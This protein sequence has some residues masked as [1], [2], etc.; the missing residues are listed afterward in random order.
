MQAAQVAGQEGSNAAGMYGTMGSYK[1]G[2]DKQAADNNPFA[3]LL[4]AGVKLGTAYMAYGSDRRLKEN[5]VLVGKD[6]RTGLNLYEF[7]YTKDPERRFCGVMADE[8]QSVM[9]NAVIRGADGFDSVCYGMLGLE[10]L[11]VQEAS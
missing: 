5:I 2:A 10:M 3:T 1:L 4:G 7:N 6:E 9:P 8:V 11:E